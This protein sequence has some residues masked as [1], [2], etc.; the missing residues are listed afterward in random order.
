LR[1]IDPKAKYKVTKYQ[2]YEPLP[3]ETLTGEE[4]IR[5]KAEISDTPGSVLIEYKKVKNSY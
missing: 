4:L 2:S 3:A 5:S 1:E